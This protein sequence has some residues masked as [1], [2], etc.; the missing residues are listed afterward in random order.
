MLRKSWG[1]PIIAALLWITLLVAGCGGSSAGQGGEDSA[2][3]VGTAAA[4]PTMPPARFTAVA[5]QSFSQTLAVTT[6][7]TTTT[8]TTRAATTADESGP[9]VSADDLARGAR[10]YERNGCADCHGPNGE[11]VAD[12]GGAI[13]GAALSEAEF[14]DVLRTGAGLGSSHIFG[15]SAISP[16]GM[17]T[18]YL[19][20]QS[21]Q[22]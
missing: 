8:M 2:N 12:K 18:L 14:A 10:S 9:T 16:G 3:A 4:V 11:G 6:T 20:V 21:L 1:W 5:Q 13:A 22:Q 15:P 19:Y 7:T 17:T